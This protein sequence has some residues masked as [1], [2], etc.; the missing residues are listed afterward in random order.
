MR[1]SDLILIQLHHQRRDI[2]VERFPPKIIQGS[3][4]WMV[5]QLFICNISLNK[6]QL[7]Y[8]FCNFFISA[9]MSSS[10]LFSFGTFLLLICPVLKFIKAGCDAPRPWSCLAKTPLDMLASDKMEKRDSTWVKPKDMAFLID[11]AMYNYCIN[12]SGELDHKSQSSLDANQIQRSPSWS[13]SGDLQSPLSALCTFW[14]FWRLAPALWLRLTA[15]SKTSTFTLTVPPVQPPKR[16]A[17][18]DAEYQSALGYWLVWY[19]NV[20]VK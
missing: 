18:A 13:R 6:Y 10:G 5:W 19:R 16:A 11:G 15:T 2:L 1:V 3:R 20:K 7:K 14:L 8:F 4:S 9:I 12:H 17:P